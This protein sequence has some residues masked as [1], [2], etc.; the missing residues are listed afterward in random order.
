MHIVATARVVAE[1]DGSQLN[2]L[3]PMVLV[4]NPQKNIAG[5][6]SNRLI[7]DFLRSRGRP[8]VCR[9]ATNDNAARHM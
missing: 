1:V 2:D 8:N 9:A 7:T 3:A 6:P 5:H 4:P